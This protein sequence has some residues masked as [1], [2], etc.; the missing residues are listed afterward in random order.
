MSFMEWILAIMVIE[1]MILILVVILLGVTILQILT[2]DE[3][4]P[5]TKNEL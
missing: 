4:E 1:T 5:E 3:T 2:E